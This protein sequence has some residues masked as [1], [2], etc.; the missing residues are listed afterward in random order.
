MNSDWPVSPIWGSRMDR[1][2]DGIPNRIWLISESP[3][4]TSLISEKLSAIR[5]ISESPNETSPILESP[6]GTSPI[7][8]SPTEI[9]W[10]NAEKRLPSAIYEIQ[11]CLLVPKR[12]WSDASPTWPEIDQAIRATSD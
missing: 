12:R 7:S 8:Q 10:T 6:R 3:N 5:P 2:R 1:S 4:A 11:F 9:S